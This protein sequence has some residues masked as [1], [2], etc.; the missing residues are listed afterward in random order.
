MGLP[1]AEQVD[2]LLREQKT[3][4]VRV[5]L[6]DDHVILRQGLAVMLNAEEDF[7]VCRRGRK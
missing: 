1:M 5:L 7:E 6:V 2:A 3:T 4:T